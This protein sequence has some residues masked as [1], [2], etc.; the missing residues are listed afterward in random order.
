M[1]SDESI[2]FHKTFAEGSTSGLVNLCRSERIEVAGVAPTRRNERIGL[3][4]LYSERS[5][6]I[7]CRLLPHT[8]NVIALFGETP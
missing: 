5:G 7:Y 8:R 4:G 6:G 1:V 2:R 3:P